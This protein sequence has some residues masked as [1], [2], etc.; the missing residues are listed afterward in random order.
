MKV[1]AEGDKG[2]KSAKR[3]T[4]FPRFWPIHYFFSRDYIKAKNEG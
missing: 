2:K 1:I 3:I 4:A